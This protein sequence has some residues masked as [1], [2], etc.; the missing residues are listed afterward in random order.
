MQQEFKSSLKGIIKAKSVVAALVIALTAIFFTR[1][2]AEHYIQLQDN[3]LTISPFR[4]LASFLL[5]VAYLYLRA[6][7]WKSL[8]NFLGE[9]INKTNSLSIWFFSEATRY[10]PGSVWVFATRT[11][12]ARQKLVS[13][14]ASLLVLPIEVI[15]V[16]S[17]T[18]ALSLYAIIDN[19]DRLPVNFVFY[20]ALLVPLLLL[21]GFIL[22]QK[23]IRRTVAKLLSLELNQTELL[24][25]IVFQAV[26]WSLYS[27]GT[28]VLIKGKIDLLLFSSTLLAWLLG[29]LSF[30]SPMGIGVRESAFILLT[31]SLIGNPQAI[32]IAIVSRVILIIAEFSILAFLVVKNRI[33][34]N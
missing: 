17:V 32:V 16:I 23:I 34:A 26:C 21:V 2:L 11:H 5:F 30:I 29:Y 4:L 3:L 14:N 6:F 8:V 10:I 27:A 33:K 15:I 20:G 18:S 12:L 24:K 9:N 13:K 25:A 22:L 1:T 31:G 7:S 19:L 28:L